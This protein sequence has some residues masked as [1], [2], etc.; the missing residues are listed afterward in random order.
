V[1]V[2]KLYVY[3][4]TE[5][6]DIKGVFTAKITLA[7]GDQLPHEEFVFV[8]FKGKGISLLGVKTAQFLEVLNVGL[9][10]RVQTQSRC[11]KR[12]PEVFTGI[13]SHRLGETSCSGILSDSV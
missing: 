11:V 3:G 12:F 8:A 1:S 10:N 6:L 9:V 7:T 13:S 2:S 4:Q 5:A